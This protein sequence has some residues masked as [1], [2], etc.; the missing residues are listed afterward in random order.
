[1][2]TYDDF[3]GT[4]FTLAAI[5]LYHPEVLADLA[6]V[7]IDNHPEG[8]AAEHLKGLESRVPCCRYVPFRGYRSTAVRDLVFREANSD[9]VL[10][11]DSHVLLR[12]GALR[13]LLDHFAAN[14]ATRDLLQGPVLNEQGSLGATHFDPVWRNGMFGTWGRDPRAE[15]PAAPAFEIGMQGLGAFACRREA[16]PGLNPRL[17]GFGAEEGYLHEKIRRNGGRVLCLP[18]LGWVHRAD[19]PAGP[20]YRPTFD[21][22]IR[23]YLIAWSELGFDTDEVEAHFRDFLG[24]DT[25]N[26]LIARARAELTNPF[27]FF[28]AVYCIQLDSR[29]DEWPLVW[30]RFDNLG[31]GQM[32]QRFPAIAT[33]DDDHAGW[34]RTHRAILAD[35]EHRGLRTVLVV[36]EGVVFLDDTLDVMARA[37]EE[38]RGREWDLLYLGGDDRRPAF[39]SSDARALEAPNHPT[40]AHA[41]A[42]HHTV[43]D[44]ILEDVPDDDGF[45]AWLEDHTAIDQYLAHMVST[46]AF[47]AFVTT[48]RVASHPGLLNDA[49]RA[50]AAHY[51]IR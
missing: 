50:L 8:P 7:V 43:F 13:A 22:R 32:V 9:Y 39:P 11:L 18:A 24:R 3:D 28:D 12:P 16:W 46:G 35:A 37:L 48:P 17:R 25:A 29:A 51:T 41:V 14:P 31:M 5:V 45:A 10:C 38:L 6:F 21:D 40:S 15:D 44:R 27:S 2:A 47:R 42:Y 23:N 34:A 36:E 26:P 33:P 1:M 4:F 49:D 20:P 30:H 19:R